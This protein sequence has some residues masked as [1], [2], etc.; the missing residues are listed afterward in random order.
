M[1]PETES[2]MELIVNISWSWLAS[3]WHNTEV[4]RTDR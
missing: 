1:D 4:C 2:F 3:F